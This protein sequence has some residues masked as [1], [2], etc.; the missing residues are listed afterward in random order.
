[1]KNDT[2][3]LVKSIL[4][5]LQPTQEK[6]STSSEL[7]GDNLSLVLRAM[8]SL[9]AD[10]TKRQEVCVKDTPL[11]PDNPS[12]EKRHG[13][14][15]FVEGDSD[16]CYENDGLAWKDFETSYL[17]L[18]METLFQSANKDETIVLL[19][20]SYCKKGKYGL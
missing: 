8:D 10:R 20:K 13:C 3:A 12:T 14:F 4:S 5:R 19:R 18:N 9:P 16:Y 15:L 6:P 2:R 17:S 1:M 7:K 11:N